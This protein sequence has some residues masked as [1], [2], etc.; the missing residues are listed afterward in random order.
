MDSNEISM[1]LIDIKQNTPHT[2]N[3]KKILKKNLLKFYNNERFLK[4]LLDKQ[5][6]KKAILKN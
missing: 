4:S 1:L 3:I 2:N 6:R 5:R